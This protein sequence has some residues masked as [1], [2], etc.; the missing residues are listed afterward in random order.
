[1]VGYSC[2][3]SIHAPRE[4]CDLQQS[5][6]LSTESVFQFTHPGRGATS[7]DASPRSNARR[8]NSRTPGGVRPEREAITPLLRSFQFTHPGRGATH[9]LLPWH[10]SER[11]FQFTHPGRGATVRFA[12][13][14]RRLVFQFTH[15]GR[16]ATVCPSW[17]CPSLCGFNSRTPGGVRRSSND[18]TNINLRFNSR[19]PGGVRRSAIRSTLN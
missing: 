10:F 17:L 19:T 8:F 5:I 14:N 9:R 16:G 7:T 1:M 11:R 18:F 2:D 12:S 13:L 6:N 3:V 4:G 15:P